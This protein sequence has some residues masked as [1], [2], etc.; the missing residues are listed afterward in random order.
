MSHVAD[1]QAS[2][3]DGAVAVRNLSSIRLDSQIAQIENTYQEA[4][5]E[6]NALV[7]I[8]QREKQ[9]LNSLKSEVAKWRAN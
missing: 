1:S 2:V 3:V 8:S 5:S 7:K 9:R 4:I 6:L